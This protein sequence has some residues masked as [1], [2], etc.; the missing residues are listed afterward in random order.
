MKHWGNALFPLGVLLAL[1]A[2]TF[3][4]RYAVELPD[5]RKDGR[6][7]HDPDYIIDQAQIRKLDKSGNLQYRLNASQ[8]RHYPDNDTT[9]LDAPRI[10]RLHP[11]QPPVTMSAKSA[12]LSQDGQLLELYE[13]VRILREAS[14]QRTAMLA[15]MPDLTVRMDEENAHTRSPVVITQGDSWLKGVGLHVDS[16]TQTYVLESQATGFFL[17]QR[18]DKQTAKKH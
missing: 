9:D 10:V 3:W 15:T 2:L 1:A 18:S 11:T 6:Y 8:I 17:S 7:R 16:K 4:L 13:N 12:H 5:E 14:A